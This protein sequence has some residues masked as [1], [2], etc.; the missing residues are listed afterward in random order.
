MSLCSSPGVLWHY[1]SFG[2]AASTFAV[3]VGYAV[4]TAA[5]TKWRMKYRR[6]MN[7][8]DREANTRAIDSLLNFETVKYFSNER[9]E[10]ERFDEAKQEYVTAAIANQRS[11][12]LFNIGQAGI[13]ST[14]VVIVMVLAA[15]GV[16][17]GRMTH[18]RFRD[19]ECLSA[20]ALSAAEHAVLGVAHPASGLHRH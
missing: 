6:E 20:A 17:T 16:T 11:L 1:L 4:Y 12:S 8:Q 14:G 13:L 5:A 19:G 3:V 9:H 2:L 10:I 7:A 18:R 15:Y